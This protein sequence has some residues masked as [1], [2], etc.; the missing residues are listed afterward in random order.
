MQYSISFI[1]YLYLQL[2]YFS[3][4]KQFIYSNQFNLSKY[5]SEPALYAF[6]HNRLAMMPFARPKTI[7]VNVLSSDHRDG[8]TVAQVMRIFGFNTIFGSSNKNS[9][10]ALK[11]II[12]CVKLGQSVA[13][14]PDGPKGPKNKINGNIVA[15]SGLCNKYII[16]MSYS[17]KRAFVFNSWDQF[18]LPTPFNSLVIIYGDPIKADRDSSE[19]QLAQLNSELEQGL[20]EI[21]KRADRVV[22]T[23]AKLS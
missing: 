13:I 1:L 4:K 20:N 3:S 18:I 7:K 9:F 15:I 5:R 14:T 6:W 22:D 2:V 17:C 16:P 19:A 23:A 8:R 21:T 10:F 12:K 11:S